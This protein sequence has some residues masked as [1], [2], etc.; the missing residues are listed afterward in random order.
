[1]LRDIYRFRESCM[2][3]RMKRVAFNGGELAP[4]LALRSDLDVYHRGARVLEN[5]DV[6]QM[7]GVKRRRG[8]RPMLDALPD[9]RLFP[10]IYNSESAYLV[11]VSPEKVRVIGRDG[12]IVKE[13]SSVWPVGEVRQLRSK[14]INSLLMLT[15]PGVAP[16][17]LMRD[18]SGGW[19]LSPF[20]FKNVP[21]RDTDL[22]SQS[23]SLERVADKYAVTFAA[24][25]DGT[26]NVGDLLR[27]TVRVS[28]QSAFGGAGS[29]YGSWAIISTLSN[30]TNIAAGRRACINKGAYWEWWTCIRD[31]NGA[32]H[33]VAGKTSPGDYPDF[34]WQGAPVG[35]TLTSKGAWRFTC[36]GEW[37]GEYAVERQYPGGSWECLGKSM[38]AVGAA[39][40]IVLTGDESN[41]EC[42]LR[43][44]LYQSKLDDGGNPTVG[45]VPDSCGNKLVVSAY[46]K[47]V[48][49]RLGST[50]SQ[51][52]IQSFALYLTDAARY[53]L[54]EGVT[55]SIV[56]L[57]LG[58][59]AV[60]GAA[61]SI[62]RA[63]NY[64]YVTP[65]AGVTTSNMWQGQLA[66]LN[67]AVDATRVDKT[68]YVS[69][70]NYHDSRYYLPGGGHIECSFRDMDKASGTVVLRQLNIRTGES[71]ECAREEGM[72]DGKVAVFNP[73][74]IQDCIYVVQAYT[75]SAA[76][77]RFVFALFANAGTANYSGN[78]E[79]V[80]IR[81][82]S[83]NYEIASPIWESCPARATTQDWSWGAWSGKFGYPALCDVYNQRLVLAATRAQ[84]QTVW[85]SRADDID[86]FET[87]KQDDAALALTMS[88]TTQNPICWM[89]AQ[90]TRLLLGTSDAEWVI[91][92]GSGALTHATARIDNHGYVGSSPVPAVMAV[93]KVL[94]CERGGG[95]LF[96]YGYSFESDSYVSRDL[97]V[98][99][100]HILPNG[101]GVVAGTVIRKPEARA[102]LVLQDGSMALMT[103]NSMH[104]VHCW[105]RYTTAGKILSAVALPNGNEE[106]SLF[107]IVE[108]EGAR[109][110]E[111]VDSR[112]PYL[113]AGKYD[114]VSTMVTTALTVQQEATGK[115]SQ[116]P[117]LFCL[118]ADARREGIEVTSDG[119]K[120]CVLDRSRETLGQ[121]W[122][123]LV[124]NGKWDYERL[125]G[126]RVS[127]NRP[128][129]I[130]G[131]QG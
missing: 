46:T 27:A 99:A 9:S 116:G 71:W 59:A 118:G 22:R 69:A 98:F 82:Q 36:S 56:K 33:F 37:Y 100:G 16:H 90:S 101:G 50:S 83:A 35:A 94:Y 107:L 67:W 109:L 79:Q 122:H 51:S 125:V 86:N 85:M 113:D 64:L 60:A 20:S 97:T 61:G 40:N 73:A 19:S 34:F 131:L 6:S 89:M 49:L 129:E 66:A 54:N 92:S 11:E 55:R 123:E 21:W 103:Y 24:G 5:W 38:S 41:E 32:S 39:A 14:Q 121:G 58:G 128:L 106:D 18:E 115:D 26:A 25:A 130:L 15:C 108:R 31:F 3:E 30:S 47:D 1:M 17:Q 63:G 74:A 81:T 45:F 111:C 88:T 57:Y 10:Y 8:M 75:N 102:A 4:D 126:I 104:E 48:V 62:S 2:M 117:V 87:G 96:Q 77:V 110:I 28:G 124:T 119:S 91:S 68:F 52:G 29:I 93:D 120:W 105:H 84:P 44:M 70:S 76:S 114:Y 23:I 13:L 80:A 12:A 42:R 72:T 112:S 43:L 78:A 65:T 7:G 127:G 95:R 53:M